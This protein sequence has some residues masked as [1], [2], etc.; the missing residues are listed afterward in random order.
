M[1]EIDELKKRIEDLELAEKN[2]V[3]LLKWEL[4]K[5]ELEEERKQKQIARDTADEFLKIFG[6]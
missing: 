1:N 4:K 2:R 6:L 3:M 5:M